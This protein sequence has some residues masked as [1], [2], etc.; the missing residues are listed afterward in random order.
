[1]R[2]DKLLPRGG[3]LAL[4]GRR[5]AMALEDITYRLVADRVPE[6]GQGAD[7]QVVAPGAI[8][9]RHAYHQG[10]QLLVNYGA[11]WSLA[12]LGA[13]TLLGHKL[14]VPAENRV[15]LDDRGDFLQGLLAQLLA[16]VRQG[17]ALAV[18]SPEAPLELVAEDA[19]LR[20]QIFIA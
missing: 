15:G 13:V 6:I 7:N 16:E 20:D 8:L 12:P 5:E 4:W 9:P 1:M 2:A 14:A 17:L 18:T 19:I 10:L 11:P 3:R